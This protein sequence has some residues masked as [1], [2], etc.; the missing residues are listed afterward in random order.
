MSGSCIALGMS[1][2]ADA[3]GWFMSTMTADWAS[4]TPSKQQ[5]VTALRT[6][7]EK[8]IF[9]YSFVLCNE[10]GENLCLVAAKR[11][12]ANEKKTDCVVTFRCLFILNFITTP[13]G[14][15]SV[16]ISVCCSWECTVSTGSWTV[17]HLIIK[18]NVCLLDKSHLHCDLCCLWTVY[19]QSS[20][21]S[22]SDLWHYF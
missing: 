15:K 2:L 16:Q 12:N 17:Y 21:A 3:R 14:E 6:M 7:N 1:S 8:C 18:K 5:I 13:F 10:D 9:F 11:L 20:D 22:A 4:G 19:L